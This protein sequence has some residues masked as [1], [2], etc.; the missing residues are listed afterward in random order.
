M[1]ERVEP[2][3]LTRPSPDLIDE[4]DEEGEIHDSKPDRGGPDGMEP[5][6]MDWDVDVFA[7]T[8]EFVQPSAVAFASEGYPAGEAAEGDKRNIP[9]MPCRK[10]QRKSNHKLRHRVNN[11]PSVAFNACVARPV[12]KKEVNATPKTEKAVQGGCDRL[13]SNTAWGS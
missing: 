5:G 12:S 11:Q 1:K 10:L 7:T 2:K 4:Y 6:D 3:A 9:A 13:A 8:E